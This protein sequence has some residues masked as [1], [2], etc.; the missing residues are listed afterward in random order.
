MSLV[1]IH[2]FW[3]LLYYFVLTCVICFVHLF[4]LKEVLLK[5]LGE[6]GLHHRNLK[7][8]LHLQG[9]F[10][11][12]FFVEIVFCI[13]FLVYN[14]CKLGVFSFYSLYFCGFYCLPYMI[15]CIAIHFRKA[16]PI[17][18]SLVLHVDSLTRNV[19]EGHLREIFSEFFLLLL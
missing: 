2:F 13:I 4:N 14:I 9:K 19:N 12:Y 11:C 18:E 16:S 7:R 1:L 10:I 8:F 3:G 5:E 6:V 15:F 17:R